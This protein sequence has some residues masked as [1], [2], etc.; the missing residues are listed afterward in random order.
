MRLDSIRARLLA[1]AALWL[2]LALLVS[3]WIIGAVLTQFVTDRFDAEAAAIVDTV[4]AGVEMAADGTV[5]V[6]RP[7]TDPRL[8]M[9]LSLWAWQLQTA[10]GRVVARA[11][12]LLDLYLDPPK[13][14][15]TGGVITG[16]AGSGPEGEPLRVMRR[17]FTLADSASHLAVTVTAPQAEIDAAVARVRRPLAVALIVLGRSTQC[18]FFCLWR[19]QSPICLLIHTRRA[20]GW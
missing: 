3:W 6:A 13:G 17:P 4:I 11:P 19:G 12:S 7:P 18:H 9:P 15:M 14:L 20:I 10:D 5:T 2:T 16:G 1:A 8:A